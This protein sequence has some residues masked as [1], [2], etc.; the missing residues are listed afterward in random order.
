VS[1][2]PIAVLLRCEDQEFQQAQAEAA[3]EAGRQTGKAIEL[4][5][6]ENSA[7]TQIQQVLSLVKLPAA[8]RPVAIVIELVAG[9]EGYMSTARA[10]LSAGIAWIE[11]S[12]LASS[13][14]TLR[15]EFPERLVLSVTSPEQDI[16]RIH[17]TQCRKILKE[18]GDILYIEGPSLQPEAKA[19]RLG[20]EEGLRSSR[21]QIEKTLCGDW[22]IQS[23]ERVMATFLDRPHNFMPALVCAQNDEMAMGIRR[24]ATLRDPAWKDIPYI[25]CDGLIT[26]GQKFVRE[27]LLTATIV[28][29]VTTGHAVTEVVHGLEGGAPTKDIS[30]APESFPSIER[31]D[32]IP[33]TSKRPTRL[34]V[35]SI[36]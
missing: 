2:Q 30:I 20:L 24:V 23:A 8:E 6:A 19:R 9:A 12:G 1:K 21:T 13:V 5:F 11:V 32:E 33:C 17:A 29:P 15:S 10:A 18:G 14:A 25:G 16:G 7:F 35:R 34:S 22:T 28:K 31:L 26:G 36:G 27:G 3:R 4:L